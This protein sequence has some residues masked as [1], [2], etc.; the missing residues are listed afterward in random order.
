MSAVPPVDF[1]STIR[2]WN[3]S[4]GAHADSKGVG[5]KAK[6]KE[7]SLLPNNQQCRVA[8]LDPQGVQLNQRRLQVCQ[9]I[10]C[11]SYWLQC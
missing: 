9:N 8:R 6:H 4:K 2:G 7:G 5:A 10:N 11:P 1:V 3:G